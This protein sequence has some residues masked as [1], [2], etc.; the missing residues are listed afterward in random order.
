MSD[1]LSSM[2][3]EGFDLA[4]RHTAA[5]PDTHVAWTLCSTRSVL[6]AT[7]SYLRRRGVPAIPANLVTQKLPAL[8][9]HAE[10][11]GLDL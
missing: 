7:R 3:T 2:G 11:A 4:I 8:P 6:V 1:R 9:S 10:C 5:P